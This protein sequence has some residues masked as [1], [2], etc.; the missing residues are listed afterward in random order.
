MSG[1]VVTL[2]EITIVGQIPKNFPSMDA[3]AKAA[4][5]KIIPTSLKEGIEYSGPV[6][7]VSGRQL[8]YTIDPE[9]GGPDNSS[10][11]FSYL[12]AMGKDKIVAVYHTHPV[13]GTN[14][15]NFSGDDMAI[16]VKSNLVIYLG[17]KN[18]IK[19][20]TPKGLL[21]ASEQEG[22]F[23]GFQ[24]KTIGTHSF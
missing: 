6:F 18:R 7:Q 1:G 10:F 21:P 13:I 3:A 15:E 23:M 24:Q 22:L 16:C 9:P 2:P 20:I 17:T 11:N 5:M 12:E 8:F 4:F 14:W 19:K